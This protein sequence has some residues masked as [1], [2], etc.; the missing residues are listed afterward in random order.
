MTDDLKVIVISW[1]KKGM[2][3][4]CFEIEKHMQISSHFVVRNALYL[5]D[6]SRNVLVKLD[7]SLNFV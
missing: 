6:Q 4:R 7:I 3:M 1:E 2:E 5:V